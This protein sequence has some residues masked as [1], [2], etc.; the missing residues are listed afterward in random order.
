MEPAA[1]AFRPD[2]GRGRVYSARR[3]V[4]STDVTPA[5]RLRL[6]AFARYLQAVAED[7]LADSRLLDHQTVWLVRRCAI[8]ARGFPQ[9]GDRV[10]LR[11]FCSGTGARW[12]ERT[13]TLA[14]T[15]GDLLQATA[16]WAAVDRAS[17]RP[18]PPG[19]AFGQMYGE[20]ADGHVVSARLTHRRPPDRDGAAG[21]PWPL[22]AADFDTA[23]HVNNAVHWAAAE[24]LLAEAG[25]Q[26]VTAE[27]EYPR[28]ILPGQRPRLICESDGRQ[29]ALWLLDG[30]QV[31][32]FGTLTLIRDDGG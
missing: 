18:V 16:V 14:G 10:S 28:A 22:R 32:A 4:R 21:R 31:L 30:T 17:G 27:M 23:G 29:R 1:P 26:P 15:V 11:T 8:A 20:S 13:T 7:D 19:E 6:D 5:G 9:M 3:I 25:W 24:D 2:P 12:A